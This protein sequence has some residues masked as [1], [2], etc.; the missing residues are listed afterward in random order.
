MR[1]YTSVLLS[2]LL[3]ACF[4]TTGQAFA[5]RDRAGFESVDSDSLLA[6]GNNSECGIHDGR[7]C[8]SS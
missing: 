7:R 2:A 8:E 3:C 4:A 1:V 6:S 5:I